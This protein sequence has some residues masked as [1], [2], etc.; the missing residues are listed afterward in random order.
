MQNVFILV[1]SFSFY[2]ILKADIS[3]EFQE[4]ILPQGNKLIG[5]IFKNKLS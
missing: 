5:K 3:K 2:K 1:H 4:S